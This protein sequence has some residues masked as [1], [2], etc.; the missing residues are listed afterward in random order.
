M[1]VIRCDIKPESVDKSED[2]ENEP[3][4]EK[5]R[6]YTSGQIFNYR[7]IFLRTKKY[8]EDTFYR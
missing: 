3:I 5:S 2:V 4:S 6:G 7:H 1:K 8:F